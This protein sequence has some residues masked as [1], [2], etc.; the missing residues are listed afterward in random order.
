[1]MFFSQ[2]I[3]FLQAVDYGALLRMVLDI[4]LVAYILYRLILLAKGTRAW[5]ILI[6]LGIFF[7]AVLLSDFLGFVTLNW[8]LRQVTPLAP[9]AIVILL[10]PELRDLLERLGRLNFWGAPLS[11][12]N[13]EDMTG[14]IE[15]I[16]K[17]ASMLA[18][19]KT[20][21]L[22]VMER[23]TGLSDIAAT[24]TP[25]DSEVSA[26]LLATLFHHGTP[27]HDGAVLIHGR[28]IVAAG[29]T[30]PLSDSPNIATNVPMRHRAAIGVSE[31]SDALVVVVSEERG[32]I[33]LA[34][35]G[36]LISGLKDDT[37]R[38]RLLEGFGQK[39][40]ATRSGGG[41]NGSSG[42]AGDRGK[43]EAGP[44]EPQ[45]KSP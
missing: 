1:M 15:E 5:Q 16:V 43:P 19:R 37:L 45:K 33:S 18:P 34:T 2:A 31:H 26:E 3:R 40:G 29:C 14:T 41:K 22:M 30:L 7:L 36:K 21:A 23:E 39:N 10:F 12:V 13:R 44:E 8:M 11:V 20:G 27:L 24:G 4:S 9:V 38:K 42:G 28:R 17:T 35:G 32:T 6:G 25:M